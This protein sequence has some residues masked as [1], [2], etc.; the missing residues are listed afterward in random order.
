MKNFIAALLLAKNANALLSGTATSTRYW[1][2]S[3][4]ACG[5][6]FGDPDH[7]A[8]CHS[9][10]MFEAPAGNENGAKYYGSAAISNAL[11]GDDWLGKGCGKCFKVTATSNIASHTESTT[12]VL[13]GTNYCPP[14]NDVC[15][16]KAHF[17]IAAP[18]FDFGPASISNTCDQVD[19]IAGLTSPQTCGFWMINSQN[20]DENC[21]CEIFPDQT[22]KDGCN[23]FRGLY[24][25]NPTV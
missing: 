8:H 21:N 23:N 15:D 6:G 12:V 17:D 14:S 1:D 11:G 22:L 9:N 4:G 5:C 16:G 25:N 20:P 10:A 24:W 7:P 19:K 3:G 13:K 2:C 18:G